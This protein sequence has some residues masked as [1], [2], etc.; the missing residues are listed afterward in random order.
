[1]ANEKAEEKE[2]EK[3]EKHQQDL[4]SSV[5][6]AAFLI[7]LGVVLLAV[8][9][10]FLDTLTS[11]LSNLSIKSYDLP[12]VSP[13]P[14]FGTNAVQVFLIG[15]GLIL[16]AEVV[17]RLLIPAYRRHVLGTIIGA[18]A[19]LSLG[20]GYWQIVGPLILVAV[21]A[22]ILLRGFIHKR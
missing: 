12:F 20:L 17:L 10:D 1:M 9:M 2:L 14:F 8:N 21:G 11:I 22:A 4:V 5:V 18:I 6:G 3:S 16:L 7:W 19:L 15:G 13:F